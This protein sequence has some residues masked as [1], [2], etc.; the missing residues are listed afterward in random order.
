MKSIEFTYAGIE[1][2]VDLYIDESNRCIDTLVGVSVWNELNREYD[3]I[4]CD[5]EAFENDME[6]V[7]YEA[8]EEMYDNQRM[9]LDDMKFDAMRDEMMENMKL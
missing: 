8:L 9:M 7:L 3:L 5:L 4:S 1:F 2:K 6:D